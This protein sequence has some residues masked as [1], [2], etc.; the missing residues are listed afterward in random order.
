LGLTRLIFVARFPGMEGPQAGTA[1][2]TRLQTQRIELAKPG[3]LG[4]DLMNRPIG[5]AEPA[6]PLGVQ[7]FV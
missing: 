7:G 4:S 2:A 1:N 3:T 5:R 6:D